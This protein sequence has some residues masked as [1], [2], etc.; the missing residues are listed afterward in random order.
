MEQKL[1]ESEVKFRG[2]SEAALEGILLLD[3]GSIVEA[4]NTIATIFG[5]NI[6]TDLIGIKAIDLISQEDRELFQNKITSGLEETFEVNGLKRD[7]ADFP[8]EVQGK[9]IT[10][11]GSQVQVTAIRDLTDKKKAEEEIKTLR[12]IIPICMHCKEIRDD[13][14]YWNQLEKY[15][16]EHS[17]AAFSHGIC[18]KCLEKIYS[19]TAK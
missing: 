5:Y 15:I 1:R 3:H 17:Y 11:R 18:D 19:K 8:I 6:P 12:G 9:I 14:G 10:Y 7:G 16:S 2:L 4:N 13:K